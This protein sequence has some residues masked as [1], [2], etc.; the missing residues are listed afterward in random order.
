MKQFF[1]KKFTKILIISLLGL[2]IVL[3][4]YTKQKEIATYQIHDTRTGINAIVT[5]GTWCSYN[6][7]IVFPE[8]MD[9]IVKINRTDN[10]N[11]T[12]SDIVEEAID[13]SDPFDD[14]GFNIIWND[15]E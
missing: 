3:S 1:Q 10:L 4:G 12:W 5:K 9:M 11:M 7:H 8:N 15:L 13:V 14:C 6:K 2:V